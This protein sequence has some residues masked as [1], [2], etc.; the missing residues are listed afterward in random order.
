M[1]RFLYQACHTSDLPHAS[2]LAKSWH[3]FLCSKRICSRKQGGFTALEMTV[4]LAIIAIMSS[5]AIPRLQGISA[6]RNVDVVASEIAQQMEAA[7]IY[8][9]SHSVVVTG[10]PVAVANL[11]DFALPACLNLNNAANWNA[12]VWFAPVNG[13]NT[14][15]MRSE[16]VPAGV[17]MISDRST[18]TIR[19][20]RNGI[21][22]ASN[23]T[24]N[25]TSP[26]AQTP[27]QVILASSGRVSLSANVMTPTTTALTSAPVTV[28]PTLTMDTSTTV[29][30]PVLSSSNV[31]AIESAPVGSL[32]PAPVVELSI[33]TT[34]A[35]APTN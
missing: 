28:L 29:S 32:P 18:S 14:I 34:T 4:V 30:T 15:I 35:A 23:L 7:R 22:S 27:Q 19:F 5:L 6:Q 25:V 24:I 21:A 2:V 16:V 33:S 1:F 11:N 31:F 26:Q 8:A 20:D 17:S 12:W 13:V 10:C 3:R 9:Q